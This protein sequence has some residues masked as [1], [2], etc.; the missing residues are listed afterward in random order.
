MKVALIDDERQSIDALKAKLEFFDA[1]IQIVAAFQSPV[2]AAE[3][4]KNYDPDVVFIDIEMPQLNGFQLLEKL[5]P[6][7]FEVVFVTAYNLYAVRALRISAFDYL[8]K[9][10][11]IE[12]L[13]QTVERLKLKFSQPKTAEVEPNDERLPLLVEALKKLANSEKQPDRIAL[14][15]QDGVLFIWT[16]DIVRVEAMSNYSSFYL[17][18]KQRVVVSKTLKDFEEILP[19]VNFV[20]VSRSAVVN[21]NH[22]T[23]YQ[24]GDGGTLSLT[25]GS[26]VEVSP[27]KK[28]DVL[29]RLAST[30]P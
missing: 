9:P 14:S 20:R 18:S 12:E 10:I 22:V 21:L 15:T 5:A 24:R 23:K 8:L 28:A 27:N 4:L 26:E 1:D 11:D 25:D 17:A 3:K 29:N 30:N 16:K 19:E 6:Y 13:T 2:E 7:R